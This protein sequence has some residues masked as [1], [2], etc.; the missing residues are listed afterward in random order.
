[1]ATGFLTAAAEVDLCLLSPQTG[2]MGQWGL[3]TPAGLPVFTLRARSGAGKDSAKK[4][5]NHQTY[6][7]PFCADA[8]DMERLF[9]IYGPHSR[10]VHSDLTW[11]CR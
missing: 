1:M 6:L 9:I 11:A 10:D 5:K 7:D 3:C 4:I 8:E 2:S